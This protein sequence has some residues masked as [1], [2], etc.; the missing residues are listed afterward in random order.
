M[1]CGDIQD[2]FSHACFY[3]LIFCG[4]HCLVCEIITGSE[5]TINICDVKFKDIFGG[6]IEGGL[7]FL[8]KV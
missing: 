1:D 6:K 4:P 8:L 5:H 3:N 2:E 7:L